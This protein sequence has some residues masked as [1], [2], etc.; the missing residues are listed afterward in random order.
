MTGPSVIRDNVVWQL[1]NGAPFMISWNIKDDQSDF[2][3]YDNDV[4]HAEHYWLSPQAIFRSRH[5]T[6]GH[7]SRYLFEDIRVEDAS[8]RLFYVILEHNKWYDPTLGYG[9]V[10]ELIFRNITA[11][12]PFTQP[13]VFAGI[14]PTHRVYD[15]TVQDVYVNGTCAAN[16]ADGNFSIDPATTDQIR[17][18]RGAHRP[19]P[20]APHGH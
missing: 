1:E 12:T 9:Q 19:C 15:V 11:T 14:D 4:I 16:A 13:N 18:V 20:D 8:W 3:V 7:M 2:H 5:A 10:S 6:P 17:I